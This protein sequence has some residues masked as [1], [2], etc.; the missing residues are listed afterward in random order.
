MAFAREPMTRPGYEKLKAELEHLRS[1]ER[2][3]ISEEIEKARSYGDISENAEYHYAK[4]KQ[5]MIEARIRDLEDKF[6][7]AEIIDLAKLSGDR[8]TFG[9][10]VELEDIETKD[11]ITYQVVGSMEAEP[12]EGKISYESPLAHALI[13]KE[14]GDDVVIKHPKGQRTYEIIKVRFGE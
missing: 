13:S 7:R 9:A 6:S 11:R 4:D 5:G 10:T 14:E 8:V 2:L 12:Q 3:K 1:G